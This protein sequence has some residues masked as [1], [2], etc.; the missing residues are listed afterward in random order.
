MSKFKR[1]NTKYPG[2]YY[3]M[4]TSIANGKPEKIYYIFYRKDGKQIEEKVGRQYQDDMTPARAARIRADRINENQL[5]NRE[6]REEQKAEKWTIDKLWQSYKENNPGL[7]GIIT[8]ENRYKN[9]IEPYFT[10]K[11]P[12]EICPFEIDKL[13]VTLLKKRKPETVKHV[14]K[15]LRRIINYGENKH[16]CD[17]IGFSIEMPKVNNEKTEDLTPEQLNRL[18]EAIDQ[19]HNIQA[20]NIMK[21]ALFTGMRR[22]EMFR[23]KWNDID[24]ERGFIY[25]RDSKG[26]KDQKIPLNDETRDL[27][28]NHPVLSEYVFPGRNG[29]QRTTIT[30]QVN[31]IKE[32]A[33]LPKDFRALHGLRHVYA[34]MLA[35]SGKVDM[36]TLQKLLTHKSPTMTQRYAHLRDEALKKASD[37]AGDIIN[38]AMNY[39]KVVNLEAIHHSSQLKKVVKLSSNNLYY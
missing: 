9:Y 15:L 25:I 18:L 16:L 38:E 23:L 3:I 20:K 4:G 21:M 29:G 22:G 31:S 19:D 36:Y 8:D 35:S 5:S 37:L 12:K 11:E 24:F 39:K 32:K 6:K 34:S 17:G 10:D 33:G 28:K 14:L 30:K 2:V 27:L 13:R 7:R 26:G 1:N